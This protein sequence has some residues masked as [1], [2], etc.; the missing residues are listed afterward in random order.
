MNELENKII[1]ILKASGRHHSKIPLDYFS[2][3]RD[4]R[5]I[6]NSNEKMPVS[7]PDTFFETWGG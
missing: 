1:R 5:H 4:G 6:S 2:W 7:Q 3:G